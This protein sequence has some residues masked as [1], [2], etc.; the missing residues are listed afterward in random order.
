MHCSVSK[1]KEF[2]HIYNGGD[3]QVTL[4]IRT[5]GHGD[6]APALTRG[7]GR[8]CPFV[9]RGRVLVARLSTGNEHP[10]RFVNVKISKIY[11]IS[12][13][14]FAENSGLSPWL[15]VKFKI[16]KIERAERNKNDKN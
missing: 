16:G 3:V 1:L 9:G 10:P 11:I 15:R 13:Y 8:A 6:P 12:K 4:F 2:N 14:F 7:T 5:A